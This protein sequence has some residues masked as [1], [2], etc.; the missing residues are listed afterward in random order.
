MFEKALEIR[1]NI[2]GDNDIRIAS[3]LNNIGSVYNNRGEYDRALE[4]YQHGLQ[5]IDNNQVE[6]NIFK[7]NLLHNC[8]IREERMDHYQTA[9]SFFIKADQ[10]YSI[11]M[12][13]HHS[14][15]INRALQIAQLSIHINDISTAIQYYQRAFHCC[16]TIWIPTDKTFK[17]L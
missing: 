15:H 11:A 12:H 13:T 16:E 2:Y 9:V 4:Y 17:D 1:K 14:R 3:S 5:I 8:G 10:I 6:A 7:A